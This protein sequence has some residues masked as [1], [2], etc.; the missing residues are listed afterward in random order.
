MVLYFETRARFNF[1]YAV[2]GSA[3]RGGDVFFMRK[4]IIL[5][6]EDNENILELQSILLSSHGYEIK[7]VK[8]GLTALDAVAE[9]HPDLV[10]LDIGLPEVDG[11]E[12][13]R[14]IKSG[15]QTRHIPVIMVTARRDREDLMKIEAVGADWYIPKPFRA[16]MVIE[17]V[18]R[19]LP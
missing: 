13:C 5:I 11:F 16:A 12:V 15:E 7:G 18:R 19:F 17:T 6:V 4:K 10:I 1:F 8:D 9:M 3:G 14:R 2:L